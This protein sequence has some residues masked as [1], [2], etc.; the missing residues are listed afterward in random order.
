MNF[1]FAG[2]GVP[3]LSGLIYTSLALGTLES[4]W[5]KTRQD[6]LSAIFMVKQFCD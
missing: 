2:L 6:P 4:F 1:Q 3:E 5:M